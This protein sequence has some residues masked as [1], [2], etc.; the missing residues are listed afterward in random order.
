MPR[1][2]LTFAFALLASIVGCVH[3]HHP[4]PRPT[5]PPS[6]L[7]Y[8]G[9]NMR[10]PVEEIARQFT[11]DTGVAVTVEVNDPRPLVD[12]IE[13]QATADNFVCHDP[14]LPILIDHGI[15]PA[16]AYTAASLTPMIA[17][18]KGN[19]LNIRS[20]ADMARPGV[21]VG[22]TER[23]VM[24]GNI[25]RLMSK[26]AGVESA[27]AANVRGEY[28]A[29]RQLAEALIR[30]EIDAGLIWNI[31]I[32]NNRDKLEA[33]DVPAAIRPQRGID[34]EV[35]SPELG[36]VELDYVRI[37]VAALAGSR[38]PAEADAF[39]R[40]VASPAGAKV[41]AA[42][43]FSPADPTRPTVMPNRRPPMKAAGR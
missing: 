9:I 28:S 34:A 24:T 6:L 43:G 23:S 32:F 40:Y 27:F 12:K 1:R 11:A 21:R 17:V 37:T 31:V 18:K 5:R 13:V 3:L 30:D 7:C 20:I 35:F 2:P 36:D 42:Y 15:A 22:L 41:F 29:G 8:A 14:F 4:T 16:H 26:K 19:P 10:R 39:A 33:V 25:A 38:H